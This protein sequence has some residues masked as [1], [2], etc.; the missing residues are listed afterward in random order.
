MEIVDD[1]HVD[2][3][4]KRLPVALDVRFDRVGCAQGALRTLD[5][6]VD[7]GEGRDRLRLAVLENL[8]IVLRETADELTAAIGHD[9]VDL[10]VLD[11]DPEG[12]RLRSGRRTL[13][14]ERA[15]SQQDERNGKQTVLH[16]DPFRL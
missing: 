14:A 3:A 9:R 15:A 11:I 2:A 10:D 7:D 5:R 4:V 16:A 13:A 8:K 12:R 1:H 6:D